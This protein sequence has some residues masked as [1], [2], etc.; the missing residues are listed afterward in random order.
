MYEV[1]ITLL[2]NLKT[3][4]LKKGRESNCLT[5][6]EAYSIAINEFEEIIKEMKRANEITGITKDVSG[7]P[8]QGD[9]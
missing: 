6:K 8:N 5:T 4:F 2:N 1:E 7:V 9:K 3:R